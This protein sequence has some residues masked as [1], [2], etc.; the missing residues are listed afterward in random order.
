MSNQQ[1]M[2]RRWNAGMRTMM[3]V[4]GP[5]LVQR[6]RHHF[7]FLTERS[8]RFMNLVRL[9]EGDERGRSCPVVEA[10]HLIDAAE[11]GRGF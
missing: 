8:V 7:I 9:C 2:G 5:V 6:M 1:I 4:A 11:R 3:T 10:E